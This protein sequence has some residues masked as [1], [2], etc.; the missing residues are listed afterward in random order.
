MK[1]G[2][3]LFVSILWIGL[4]LLFGYLG[5][6][7]ISYDSLLEKFDP[8]IFSDVARIEP[9]KV[10]RVDNANS[11]EQLQRIIQE[12]Q[13]TWKKISI[14]W[15]RHSQGGHTYYQD[16]IVIDMRSYNKVLSLDIPNKVITV[17]AGAKWSEVQ[18][19][20]N[21]HGLSIKVMQSSNLFT[22]WGTLSANAH[23]RDLDSA[24]FIETVRSFRLLTASGEI[25]DVSR[26]QHADIFSSVIGGY[27]LFGV[28]LDVTIDLRD[29]VLY[30]QKSD[31]ITTEDLPEY[32]SKNIQNNTQVAMMLAR[33]SIARDTF[34]DELV[35]SRW[36][37]SKEPMTSQLIEL[38]REQNVWRD[39]FFF[40]LSRKFEWAK[41]MRWYLQKKVELAVDW[42]RLMTRNNSMRPPLAPLEFLEYYSKKDT[43]II[44]EYYIPISQ[45]SGFIKDFKKILKDQKINVI[46]FTI[47]YVAKNNETTLAYCPT[48]DCFAIIFMANVGLDSS[49][50]Q[51][52]ETTT[53][54]LVGSA[55]RHQ[56][57]YYLTYQ[58]YP[59]K[60]QIT[61]MYPK[62][63]EFVKF[64][65]QFD[66]NELFIN[67]FYKKYAN[68]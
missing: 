57:S 48:E 18:E 58:L 12:A 67:K 16:N 24:S 44:Q 19:Y 11:T 20:V 14:A 35:V 37:Y 68:N 43:D 32:F 29:N 55:I 25:L 47:R 40:G 9:E 31:I 45:Y 34:F 60:A 28:I 36:E 22:V 64:K 21:P 50:Q 17:Q 30:V 2:I 65:K 13:K 46:S 6:F 59:T 8:L 66:P 27:G 49:S 26:L 33:P 3:K 53:Q 4:I 52:I 10:E 51:H 1:K 23:G 62:F 39:K 63:D 56:W 5:S 7:I 15:S 42:E 54:S 38:T 61:Q 41:D